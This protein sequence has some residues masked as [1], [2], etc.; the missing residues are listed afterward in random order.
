MHKSILWQ[1]I[2]Q[3]KRECVR[4]MNTGR[5]WFLGTIKAGLSL[6]LG[7]ILEQQ[8]SFCC[9][10][11]YYAQKVLGIEE[12]NPSET[13]WPNP[14]SSTAWRLH[15]LHKNGVKKYAMGMIL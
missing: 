5:R 11:P 10:R 9:Y 3:I 7:K 4:K 15:E 6:D 2:P 14:K 13:D 1:M 8:E 12:L